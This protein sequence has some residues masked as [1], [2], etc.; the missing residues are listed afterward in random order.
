MLLKVSEVVDLSRTYTSEC[1][2]DLKC[3]KIKEVYI[4]QEFIIKAE[5]DLEMKNNY[6]NGRF[7]DVPGGVDFSVFTKITIAVGSYSQELVVVGSPKKFGGNK[8][9]NG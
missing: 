6:S 5:E 1:R 2:D 3:F 9:L 4:N 7:K 8:V